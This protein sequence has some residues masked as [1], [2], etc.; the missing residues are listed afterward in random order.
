MKWKKVISIL[1]AAVLC[2][3]FLVGCGGEVD[4][5]KM[6]KQ[7]YDNLSIGMLKFQV[8]ES[9]GLD[10]GKLVSK[11]KENGNYIFVVKYEGERAGS[12]TL[13]FESSTE[14]ESRAKLISMEEDGLK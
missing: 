13:T 7:E 4:P 11:K 9:I 12:A 10:Q 6:S 8:D 5:K 1:L 3:S 2:M 14:L